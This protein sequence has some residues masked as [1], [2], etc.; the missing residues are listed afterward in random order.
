MGRADAADV[1]QPQAATDSPESRIV[2]G[3]IWFSITV[4]V[5][6]VA[7][8][9]IAI[10]RKGIFGEEDISEAES[11]FSLAHLRELHKTGMLTDEEYEHA[12]AATI[13]AISTDPKKAKDVGNV[14]GLAIPDPSGGSSD[15]AKAQE[16]KELLGGAP[17]PL[18]DPD[19]K[20]GDNEVELGPNLL[21]GGTENN[22]DET[23]RI[24]TDDEPGADEDDA[25]KKDDDG[26]PPIPPLPD[27]PG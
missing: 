10:T 22:Q 4:V 24:D 11:A 12:K 26:L 27:V 9:I 13:A 5:V 6:M 7:V 8:V 25:D 15:D 1:A 21:D 20:A 19:S 23:Y 14:G 17:P 3:L 16:L 18:P 2:S